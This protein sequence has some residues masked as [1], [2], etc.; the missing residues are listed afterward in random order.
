MK[1]SNAS[2]KRSSQQ[3][4]FWLNKSSKVFFLF[5]FESTE[6]KL[7]MRTNNV[8]LERKNVVLSDPSSKKR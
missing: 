7:K 8:N 6:N 2:H 5:F 1:T 3:F 4:A